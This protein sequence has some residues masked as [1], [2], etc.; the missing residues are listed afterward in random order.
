MSTPL[1]FCM[2]V[3][4]FAAQA[5]TRLR[6]ALTSAAVAVLEGDPP[7]EKTCAVTLQARRLG[8]QHGMTRTELE[9]FPQ[10]T[11][12]RRSVAEERS[13]AQAL[14]EMAARFTPRVEEMPRS[15]AYTLAL[16]MTGT[17]RLLGQPHVLGQKLFRAARELGFFARVA[18][19]RNLHT[20]ACLV[21]APGDTLIVV[22]PGEERERLR[23]LPLAALDLS[24]ELLDT[25]QAWGL[26]TAGDLAELLPADLVARL[27]QQGHR[28]HRL[29]CGEEDHLLVPAEAPFTLEEH[30]SFDAPVD[31]LESLLFVLA[32]ML[33][34][35]IG[36]ARN[37]ALLLAGITVRLHLERSADSTDHDRN[38]ER[39]LQNDDPIHE[40][41]LKPALPL[42]DRALLLKL[43]Q[44]DLQSHPAPAAIVGITVHA[45]PGPRP[46]VQTGLFL[47][48]SPEP[49]RLEVTLARIA[50]LVGDDRVGRAVLADQHS[51]DSF[52]MERF[53]VTEPSQ[54]KR[55][56]RKPAA[57][58]PGP[59]ETTPV[60]RTGVSLRRLRPAPMVHVTLDGGRLQ[61]FR[62][63]SSLSMQASYK[64]RRAFGPW[65]RS[66]H[67]W[68]GEAW[69]REEWDVEAQASDGS[70]LLG[71]LV[72]D[73]L[74]LQWQLEA[75]YD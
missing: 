1:L 31:N 20:A 30:I 75:T 43:L 23:S 41:T 55:S 65:Q 69:S 17:T 6:P 72:H 68:S 37:R 47:P 66:G 14:L 11:I 45:D 28:L 54:G 62:V 12:L 32:P 40:R 2:R 48:Q 26:R 13:A 34:Q 59:A 63:A 22:P 33:D 53:S 49:M 35:L 74:R 10:L 29:A 57:S 19:S 67:W 4:E 51:E 24:A 18:S 16:D 70:R 58:A 64:V 38:Q 60:L 21:R 15:A 7:L 9:S 71:L 73:L 36:R 5:L 8:V 25:F 44:L 3:P 50:A 52:R 46:G 39:E 42:D 27:G 61:A 56:G